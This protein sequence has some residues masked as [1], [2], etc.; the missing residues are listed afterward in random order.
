MKFLIIPL[1]FIPV[2][3]FSCSPETKN[4]ELNSK[5]LIQFIPPLNTSRMR[6]FD[7]GWKFGKGDF[8]GAG[9]AGFDDGRWRTVD[10]PHDWSIE[11]LPD[12]KEGEITGPFDKNSVGGY[13]TG[14]TVGGTGW[15]RKSF[16]VDEADRNKQFS[17][18]F[19]GV[20]MESEVWL[21][22][23]LLGNHKY[24]YTPFY[25][26]MNKYLNPAGENNVLT[27]KVQNTGVNSRW[28]SGSGIYRHVWL[29]VAGALQIPVWGVYVTTPEISNEKAKVA[30]M[31][32][33]E[34]NAGSPAGF[35]VKNTIF[36]PEG[37]ELTSSE[38]T[39][40]I[41]SGGKKECNTSFDISNPERWSVNSPSLYMLKTELIVNEKVVDTEQTTFGI[42]SLSFTSGNGFLL[43]GKPVLLQGGCMHHDNGPLGSAA[44][45]RAEQRKIEILKAN[46]FN[47]IRTSHN[48]PSQSLLDACDRLGMLVVDEAFDMWETAKRKDDYH[49]FFREWHETDL[50]SMILRDR[51]HPSVIMWSIGNEIPERAD[52]SGIRIGKD[53]IRIVKE[54]DST[55]PVTNAICS[56]WESKDKV[57]EWKESAPAFALLDVCGYNYQYMRYEEDHAQYPQRVIVGTESFPMAVYDNW[58]IIREKP[59]IIGDFVWTAFDY[60]GEA[61]IGQAV[62]GPTSM[63][64]P[65][66]NANCGDIDLIGFKK[67]QSYYRD[68]VWNRSPLEMG[69]EEIAPGGKQWQISGWGWRR[70][71]QSWTW[72]GNE[73]KSM[74]VYVYS[75]C[76][77]VR[78]ELNGKVVETQTAKPDSKF[79]YLFRVPYQPGE[80]K[81]ITLADGKEVAEKSLK[82]T[83]PAAMLK[84]TADR[85]LITPD[86]ND[87]AYLT[88]ELVDSNG[89]R[90]YNEDKTIGFTVKGEAGII[91]VGNGNPTEAKS[92]QADHCKTCHGRAIVILRPSGKQG[93]VVLTATADRLPPASCNLGVNLQK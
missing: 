88:V 6:L 18:Y 85:Q 75:Q 67:Q 31:I 72:P 56:F 93:N 82:T 35:I 44:F 59:Y 40:E 64:W 37:K 52:S 84:I 83:G 22:G 63:S 76:K 2:L 49:R 20:Y 60:L 36:S 55:R 89:N 73:G 1:L 57:R 45:D 26:E 17:I 14:F 15:Y 79:V 10:L 42:R 3:F 33:I 87:L 34:N 16:V 27:V 90:V 74:N 28:Y 53:L 12:Q 70:E 58:E 24:G 66:I 41:E 77:E 92:F 5:N 68:V 43:N 30:A 32:S 39:G 29:R 78:L 48:P 11:D 21:N 61:G 38:K 25:F 62:A 46:G 4:N 9:L 8:N 54:L 80:L 71:Q 50:R 7:S 69:V 19:D 91:G 13:N 86:R 65:W 23:H 81:A 47:A 51:N